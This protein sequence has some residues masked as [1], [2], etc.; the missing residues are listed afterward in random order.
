MHIVITLGELI[1][2]IL[3]AIFILITIIYIVVRYI[4]EKAKNK[5]KSWYYDKKRG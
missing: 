5:R 4:K 2:F 3:S 1:G